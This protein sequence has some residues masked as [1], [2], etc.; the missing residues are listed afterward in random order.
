MCLKRPI[1]KEKPKTAVYPL[2][3]QK[4]TGDNDGAFIVVRGAGT[5][6]NKETTPRGEVWSSWRKR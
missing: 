1:L 5:A 2:S 4:G 6:Q 3:R